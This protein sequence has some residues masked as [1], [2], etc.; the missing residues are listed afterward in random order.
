M[1]RCG[2]DTV[3][4]ARPE[5]LGVRGFR[6]LMWEPETMDVDLVVAPGVVDVADAA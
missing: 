3:G 4:V 1:E 2:A 5:H 6:D